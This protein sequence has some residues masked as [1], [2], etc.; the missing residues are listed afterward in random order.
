MMP[1]PM[2]TTSAEAGGV[3]EVLIW[4]SGGDTC[5]SLV[6]SG[7][8]ALDHVELCDAIAAL[9]PD[10]CALGHEH[11]IAGTHRQHAAIGG[12]ESHAAGQQMH[13]FVEAMRTDDP[14]VRC[15][16]PSA[17]AVLGDVVGEDILAA[18]LRRGAQ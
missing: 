5:V 17:R 2:T 14:V 10:R 18:A 6:G 1:P 16:I 9:P 3:G 7:L 8:D 4:C 11:R 13:E 12:C 15:R